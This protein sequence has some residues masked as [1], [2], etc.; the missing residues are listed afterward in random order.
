LAGQGLTTAE[1]RRSNGTLLRRCTVRPRDAMTSHF[2]NASSAI[3]Y[4]WPHRRRHTVTQDKMTTED[5]HTGRRQAAEM[6]LADNGKARDARTLQL[7]RLPVPEENN[8]NRRQHQASVGNT[9][10]DDG[11]GRF[12]GLLRALLTLPGT[13]AMAVFLVT[14]STT[15]G[16]VRRPANAR[17]AK[18]ACH[19]T[20]VLVLQMKS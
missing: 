4:Q 10:R 8:G 14:A 2:N 18:T 13:M 20:C 1:A 6:G 17:K 9:G 16:L 5:W 12:L 15:T 11:D 19:A 7:A 3:I